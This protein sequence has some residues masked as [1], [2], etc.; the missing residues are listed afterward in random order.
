MAPGFRRVGNTQS[1]GRICTQA[2]ASAG[3]APVGKPGFG[4]RPPDRPMGKQP[5]AEEILGL[6]PSGDGT[7]YGPSYPEEKGT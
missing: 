4:V 1:A 7:V 2:S 3:A 5:S 6:P